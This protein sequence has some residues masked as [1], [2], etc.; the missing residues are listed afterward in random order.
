MNCVHDGLRPG[1]FSSHEL[2]SVHGSRKRMSFVHLG[3]RLEW[4]GAFS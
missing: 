1:S 2:S 4:V 3:L